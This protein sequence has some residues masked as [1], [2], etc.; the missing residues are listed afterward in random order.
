M[1]CDYECKKGDNGAIIRATLESSDTADDLTAYT[2]GKVYMRLVGGTT[3]KINGAS[4]TSVAAVAGKNYQRLV[5]YRFTEAD[6]DTPGLYNLYFVL[7]NGADERRFPSG[8][9][10]NT[11]LVGEN[12]E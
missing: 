11:V 3:N 7:T 10:Y 9:D 1:R 8:N 5:T 4:L 6:L 2:S 12:F